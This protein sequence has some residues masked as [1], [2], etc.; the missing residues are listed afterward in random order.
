MKVNPK[1]AAPMA[2]EASGP[3]HRDPE[4]LA[5]APGLALDR[6]DAAQE[7]QRDRRDRVSVVER[8]QRVSCL[9]EQDREVEDDGEGCASEILP[10]AEPGLHAVHG[11]GNG[12]GDEGSDD[13]PGRG[14]EY[15][16]P[17]D[18]ADPDRAGWALAAHRLQIWIDMT[19]V[20]EAIRQPGIVRGVT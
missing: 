1:A 15:V 9:V 19:H 11:R 16:D 10:A 5:R 20:F 18:L 17:R 12:D 13:E 4:L 14:D 3:D 6:R 2:I 7:V 8:S